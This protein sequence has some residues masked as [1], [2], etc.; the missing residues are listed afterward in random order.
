MIIVPDDPG[1]AGPDEALRASVVKVFD[2]DGFL[3]NVWNPHREAWV[4]RVPFRLAFIDAPE[5]AQPF[6]REAKDLLANLIA[7]KI[8]RLDP[9]S[10]GSGVGSPIDPYNRI[11]CTAFMTESLAAGA[12]DYYY[13]GEGG[14][15]TLHRP[16]EVTRN[17]E[18][19]MIV[20]GLAWVVERYA[21]DRENEYF[22]AQECARQRRRGLWSVNNPEPPWNF[23]RRQRRSRDVAGAQSLLL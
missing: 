14:S 21:F 19:E 1:V 4:R 18:L 9:V 17:V 22:K 10:K 16:R 6:G 8:L 12:V 23:K 3:A 7:G 2:G 5:M 11:L 13:R 20:N 15:G